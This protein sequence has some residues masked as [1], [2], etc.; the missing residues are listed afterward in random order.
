MEECESYGL[1]YETDKGCRFEIDKMTS[2]LF[3][4]GTRLVECFLDSLIDFTQIDELDVFYLNHEF[5]SNADICTKNCLV[6]EDDQDIFTL[7]Y[8]RSTIFQQRG[9]ACE[10]KRYHQVFA[11]N[12]EGQR[13]HP[14]YL[15]YAIDGD[16]IVITIDAESN[17]LF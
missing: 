13:Y 6:L 15:S 5:F 17:T 2:L 1:I 3:Q 12:A 9:S 7:T 14:D 10:E 11:V 16:S 4:Q 8:S